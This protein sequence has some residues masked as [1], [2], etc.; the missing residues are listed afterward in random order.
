MSLIEIQLVFNLED[1]RKMSRVE[2]INQVQ[3]YLDLVVAQ[4]MLE[5]DPEVGR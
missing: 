4:V 2:A 1:L 3:S 5:V